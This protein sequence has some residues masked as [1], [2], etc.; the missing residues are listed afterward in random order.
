MAPVKGAIEGIQG[1]HM[2]DG[3][4]QWEVDGLGR[5]GTTS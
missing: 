1:E 4:P 3:P 2:L 5:W